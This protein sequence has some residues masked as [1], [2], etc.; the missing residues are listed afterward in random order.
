MPTTKKPDSIEALATQNSDGVK[1]NAKMADRMMKAIAADRRTTSGVWAAYREND[2][3]QFVT[4]SLHA[5][6][7]ASRTAA[8]DSLYQPARVVFVPWDGSI[9]DAIKAASK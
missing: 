6:E 2:V 1:A 8:M 5:D 7:L 9:E 4:I 3:G